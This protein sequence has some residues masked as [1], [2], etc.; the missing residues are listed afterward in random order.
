MNE[1]VIIGESLADL[2]ALAPTGFALGFHIVYTTPTFMFQ[3][4]AP[5]WLEHYAQKGFL[6]LDPVVHWGFENTG[7]VRWSA[8]KHLDSSG[9]LDAAA[10]FGINYGVTVAVDSQGSRSFGGFSRGDR[11]FTDEESALLLAQ[12]NEI[13]TTTAQSKALS[14]SSIAALKKMSVTYTHTGAKA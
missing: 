6:I 2:K 9:V 10:K 5:D 11:E 8:L 3:T 14:S 13:H 7:I 12:F 4:Y 1:E